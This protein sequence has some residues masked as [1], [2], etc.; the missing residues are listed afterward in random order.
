MGR[1]HELLE[2]Q[3]DIGI[4]AFGD[5]LAEAFEEAAIALIEILG[6]RPSGPTQEHIVRASAS[7]PGA[8]LVDLL[9]ELVLLH[10]TERV[11][12]TNPRVLRLT[13]TEVEM[14]V[15]VA[16]L[17]EE[18]EAIVKGATYHQLSIQESDD[19]GAVVEVYLDV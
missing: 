15:E 4:R 12:L 11:A 18:P 14:T 13:D 16:D 17:A 5:S 8:L 9:N 7:D 2:H 19:G 6:M 3:A 1:G 10:E